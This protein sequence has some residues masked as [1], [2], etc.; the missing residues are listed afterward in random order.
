MSFSL[1]FVGHKF[2]WAE[3]GCKLKSENKKHMKDK[4]RWF[5]FLL[6][7][8]IILLYRKGSWLSSSYPWVL[9]CKYF[10]VNTKWQIYLAWCRLTSEQLMETWKIPAPGTH[11]RY[12]VCPTTLISADRCANEYRWL[13]EA[14]SVYIACNDFQM[15]NNGELPNQSMFQTKMHD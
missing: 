13:T 10:L 4:C 12:T 1:Q 14:P 2:T 7:L 11:R 8:I 6:S 15:V 9:Y 5:Y 3:K